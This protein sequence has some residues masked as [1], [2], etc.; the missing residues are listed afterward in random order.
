[1]LP[2]RPWRQAGATV[3]PNNV[4]G[5]RTEEF[6]RWLARGP[7]WPQT[8]QEALDY[9]EG[10]TVN[11]EHGYVRPAGAPVRTEEQNAAFASFAKEMRKTV[12]MGTIA[13]D[14]ALYAILQK[15][16]AKGLPPYER[17]IKPLEGSGSIAEEAERARQQG[18]QGNSPEVMEAARRAAEGGVAPLSRGLSSQLGNAARPQGGGN[19]GPLPL[20]GGLGLV[21]PHIRQ[22]LHPG[23]GGI[24]LPPVS[25]PRGGGG[26]KGPS[27]TGYYQ[28]P[29]AAD[30]PGIRAAMA[31]LRGQQ[32]LPPPGAPGPLTTE[33]AMANLRAKAAQAQQQKPPKRKPGSKPIAFVPRLGLAGIPL[34]MV[35]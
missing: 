2:A 27:R 32:Q 35:A 3:P 18:R 28:N 7:G 14:E 8:Y 12:E 15:A 34:Q 21:E 17:A 20:P 33:Q 30:I 6:G 29:S 26:G 10:T 1:M 23:M 31:G 9:A 25:Y 13:P 22:P 16:G 11:P 4:A 19:N 5:G 24:L